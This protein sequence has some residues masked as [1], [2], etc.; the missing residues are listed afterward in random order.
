M[1]CSLILIFI[2]SSFNVFAQTNQPDSVSFCQK[3]FP[4]P[5]ACAT[6]SKF[7]IFC[8]DYSMYWF[9]PGKTLLLSTVKTFVGGMIKEFDSC[10]KDSISVLLLDEKVPTIKLTCLANGVKSYQFVSYG[11]VNNQAVMTVLNLW[12]NPRTNKDLPNPIKQILRLN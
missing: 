9:Y 10:K 2:I 4:I 11:I 6:P 8:D 12:K 5:S 7:Q 1:K 3:L